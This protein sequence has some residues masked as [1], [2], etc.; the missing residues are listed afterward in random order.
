MQLTIVPFFAAATTGPSY[1]GAHSGSNT[2][3]AVYSI[4]TVSASSITWTI[5]ANTILI[6]GQGTNSIAVHYNNQFVS[7]I[8]G[9]TV[10]AT[11]GDIEGPTLAITKS[12]PTAPVAI[13]NALNV[14]TF[15]VYNTPVTYSI[16]PVAN[17]ITNQWVIASAVTITSGRGSTSLTINFNSGFSMGTTKVRSLSGCGNIEYV[18]SVIGVKPVTPSSSSGAITNCAASS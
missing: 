6:F 16:E 3:D 11:C 13:P 5:P 12:A 8:I 7:V 18:S 2:P 1:I 9:V 17:V 10:V 15:V 14:L 4:T